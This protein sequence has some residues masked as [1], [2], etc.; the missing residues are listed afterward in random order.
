MPAHEAPEEPTRRRAARRVPLRTASARPRPGGTAMA[1]GPHAPRT[2]ARAAGCLRT[3]FRVPT[4]D[5]VAPSGV[6]MGPSEGR[7][8][9]DPSHP[10]DQTVLEARDRGSATLRSPRLG[11][12]ALRR[13]PN[14]SR[15]GHEIPASRPTRYRHAGLQISRPLPLGSFA[16]VPQA[17][18]A[19]PPSSPHRRRRQL[20]KRLRRVG[21]LRALSNRRHHARTIKQRSSQVSSPPSK[22]LK[23]VARI[24]VVQFWTNWEVR[25]LQALIGTVETRSSG[26][27]SAVL[28]RCFKPS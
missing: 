13:R 28:S 2:P 24:V 25:M 22:Q 12:S 10:G 15:E 7:P 5:C 3:R 14:S 17:T 26:A 19:I 27:A 16:S 8:N 21:P 18:E 9:P 11:D 6:D 20:P 1:R 4:T 23:Q